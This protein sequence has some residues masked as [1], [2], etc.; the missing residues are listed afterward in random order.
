MPYELE[1]GH[2]GFQFVL[3]AWPLPRSVQCS[4]C[5]GRLTLA[6][7]L[8]PP[9]APEPP[10]PA[11]KPRPAPRAD[12][13]GE[14]DEEEPE[15][16]GPRPLAAP[17]P[18][19]HDALGTARTAAEVG[20]VLYAAAMVFDLFVSPFTSWADGGRATDRMLT[21]TVIALIIP[22]LIHI[23]AMCFAAQIPPAYGGRRVL[24]SVVLVVLAVFAAGAVY[25]VASAGNLSRPAVIGLTT[26]TALLFFAAAFAVWLTVL[27]RFG[28]CLGSDSLTER[29]QTVRT[30]FPFWIVLVASFLTCSM[31][32]E[33]ANAPPIAWTGRA[34]LAG[35]VLAAFWHYSGLLALAV[36]VVGRRAPEAR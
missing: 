28:A 22:V 21:A 7:P 30:W 35:T 5:G 12:D 23:G 27:A 2:C 14:D 26:C 34:L 9:T 10:K 15:E 13:A 3:D 29:A 31:V 4:V 25:S 16:F 32:G 33:S 11:P 8:S 24:A 20:G 1:C 19:I 36:G 6:V 18:T 17:W